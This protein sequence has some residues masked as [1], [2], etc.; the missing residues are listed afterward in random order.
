M[1]RRMKKLTPQM[2]RKMVMQ[3]RRRVRMRESSDPIVAG[4][5]NVDKVNAEEVDA[6][7]QADTLE[8]DIDHLKVLKISEKRLRSK[9]KK[10]SEARRTA[11]RRL[12]RKL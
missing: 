9:L 5:E 8:K 11:R 6:A 1:K 10:V 2:L 4:I 7:D 3:E 12:L